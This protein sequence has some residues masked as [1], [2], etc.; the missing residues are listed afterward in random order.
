MF[1]KL[2]FSM[3]SIVITLL[4]TSTLISSSTKVSAKEII[5]W[6]ATDLPYLEG[7]Y[8]EAESDAIFRAICLRPGV[9]KIRLGADHYVGSGSGERV[10][11]T[12]QSAGMSASISGIS[13]NSLDFE[14]TGASELVATISTVDPIFSILTTGKQ[15]TVSGALEEPGTWHPTGMAAAIRSFLKKCDGG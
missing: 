1:I 3:R 4:I 14:M 2:I 13:Q 9:V 15:V 11:L 12:L 10:N 8:D 6:T 5:K 7:R